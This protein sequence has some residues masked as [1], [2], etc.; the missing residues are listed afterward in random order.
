MRE[1]KKIRSAIVLVQ[2]ERITMHGLDL[3][4][5]ILGS[6]VSPSI[7]IYRGSAPKWAP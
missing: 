7:G 6:A 2:P 3:C 1:R 4:N 5:D